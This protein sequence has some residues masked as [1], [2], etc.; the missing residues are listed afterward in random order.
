MGKS[1]SLVSSATDVD[2][3]RSAVA[4]EVVQGRVAFALGGKKGVDPDGVQAGVAN[5]GSRSGTARV[6]FCG[7]LGRPA[8]RSGPLVIHCSTRPVG[9]GEAERMEP[10]ADT[11][12]GEQG[13]LRQG[14]GEVPSRPVCPVWAPIRAPWGS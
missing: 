12:G 5:R 4:E 3:L 6:R 9:A 10:S 7:S 11:A 2:S 13:Q 14:A 8:R 1:G